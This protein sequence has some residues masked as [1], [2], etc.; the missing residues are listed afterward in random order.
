ME[1]LDLEKIMEKKI[2][3]GDKAYIGSYDFTGKT[4]DLME[5]DVISVGG[6][7]I[8]VSK[9][10]IPI[11]FY[12]DTLMEKCEIGYSKRLFLSL[13]DYETQRNRKK[14]EEFVDK[15]MSTAVRFGNLKK[16]SEEDLDE[17]IKIIGKYE[18]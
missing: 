12:V 17:L 1:G 8:T 7:Y 2:K 15:L 4:E 10:S 14:K 11:K 6:K 18:K 3:V 5:V 9:Y 13:E 16:F